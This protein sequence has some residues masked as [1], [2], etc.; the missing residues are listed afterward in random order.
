[1]ISGDITV[2]RLLDEHPDLLE[3]L[4][5]YHPHFRQLRNKLLRRVMAPRVTVAQAARIAGVSVDDLVY[6]LRRS[7][8]QAVSGPEP[9]SSPSGPG[10][11]RLA[12]HVGDSPSASTPLTPKP[13]VLELVPESRRVHLDVRADIQRGE[14][15]F[16]RIMTAVKSLAPDQILVL[17]APFEP[18]PLYDVL[19]KR[20]FAH[21]T[22]CGQPDDWSVWFFRQPDGPVPGAEECAPSIAADILPRVIDVRGLPPP[23]PMVR[24]LEELKELQPGQRLE[25][26]H[27]RRPMFLYPQ[28][29]DRGF[30]HATD[31]PEPGVIRIV[32]QRP[33]R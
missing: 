17:R 9:S 16:V 22:E 26:L 6:A 8:G 18:I 25:V 20:R 24:I 13:G 31:E 4:A 19:A 33:G 29:D 10:G 30:S 14:E 28:L 32:I 12:E 27:E 3:V 7:S 2:A 21:W 1:V 23:E 11:S 15:P 5:S